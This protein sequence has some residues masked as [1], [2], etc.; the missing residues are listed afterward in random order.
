MAQ[1]REMERAQRA[2]ARAHARDQ[3]EALR[4]YQQERDDQAAAQTQ[5]IEAQIAALE[6][7]LASVFTTPPF[8]LAQL[9]REFLVPE[10]NSGPLGVPVPMPD[11]G[12]YQVPPP[13]GLRSLSPAARRD[14]QEACQRA[15]AQF[16]H[17]QQ[18]T[19][20]C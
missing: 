15:Q 14:H 8:Q 9:K 12:Y 18:L 3:R 13:A 11:Q 6:Q 17:D 16:E 2:A 7:I 19:V 4:L 20:V 5:E 10:F 1:Q